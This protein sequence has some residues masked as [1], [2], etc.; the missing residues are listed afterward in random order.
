MG[1]AASDSLKSTCMNLLGVKGETECAVT[2]LGEPAPAQHITGR[3]SEIPRDLNSVPEY[4]WEGTAALSA[5]GKKQ[6]P[7]TSPLGFFHFFC[8]VTQRHASPLN[9]SRN[10]IF[11]MLIRTGGHSGYFFLKSASISLRTSFL[12]FSTSGRDECHV[13]F[14]RTESFSKLY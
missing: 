8:N 11:Q 7:S 2:T 5:A 14:A 10:E 12:I 3:C 1:L 13:S 4:N 9:E 6:P